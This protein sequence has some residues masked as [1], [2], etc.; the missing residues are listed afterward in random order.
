MDT[1]SAIDKANS[2]WESS[3]TLFV[4][5]KL[6]RTE[7]LSVFLILQAL[8]Y[9]NSNPYSSFRYVFHPDVSLSAGES[10]GFIT[11]KYAIPSATRKITMS[12]VRWLL[13]IQRDEREV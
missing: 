2:L 7:S 13:D 12:S 11:T 8:G 3:S 4:N 5:K 9:L 1:S 10:T 6:S